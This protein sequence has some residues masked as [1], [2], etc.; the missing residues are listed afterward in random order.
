[1]TPT[2][3]DEEDIEEYNATG[4]E[5]RARTTTLE[6]GTMECTIYPADV[7]DDQKTARWITAERG[8]YVGL[9]QMR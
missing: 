7:H 6:D 1:M 8:S 9:C 5:L 3:F 2:E 4:P